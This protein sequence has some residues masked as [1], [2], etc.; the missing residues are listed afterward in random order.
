MHNKHSIP[1][2]PATPVPWDPMPSPGFCMQTGTSSH[3]C[4]ETIY[5]TY[6]VYLI[7]GEGWVFCFL[8]IRSLAVLEFYIDQAAGLKFRVHVPLHSS[9]R[10]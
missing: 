1:Q 5:M 9:P 3:I 10:I 4:I 6:I 8:E 7:M 2:M